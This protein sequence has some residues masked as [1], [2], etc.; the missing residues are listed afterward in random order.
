M[1][2][3]ISVFNAGETLGEMIENQKRMGKNELVDNTYIVDI[4]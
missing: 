2:I 1:T 4:L 3:Q